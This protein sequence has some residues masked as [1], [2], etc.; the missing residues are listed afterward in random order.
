MMNHAFSYF[1]SKD[2]HYYYYSFVLH[3][4]V[5]HCDKTRQS[6]KY[7]QTFSITFHNMQI[8]LIPPPV[9]K[10]LA[11]TL[12]PKMFLLENIFYPMFSSNCPTYHLFANIN[13]FDLSSLYQ[14]TILFLWYSHPVSCLHHYGKITQKKLNIPFFL[15]IRRTKNNL[16]KGSNLNFIIRIQKSTSITL[17]FAKE[18]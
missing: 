8:V 14:S 12:Q 17:L 18:I 4:R 15:R 13:F 6:N 9:G 1:L 5:P 11:K 10:R 7:R 2:V 3:S 16:Y